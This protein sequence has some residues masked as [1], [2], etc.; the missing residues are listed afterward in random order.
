MEAVEFRLYTHMVQYLVEAQE[1]ARHMDEVLAGENECTFKWFILRVLATRMSGE[2]C[3]SLGNGFANL[4]LLLFAA[5]K[6]KCEV[7]GCVEGDDGIARCERGPA[8]TAE[9]FKKMGL[10]IKLVKHSD[11]ETA[12]F[13]GLIFDTVEKRNVADPYKVLATFA[14]TTSRYA[15]ARN[16]VLAALLRCKAMCLAYQYPGCPILSSLAAYGLRATQG[17]KVSR[18][19]WEYALREHVKWNRDLQELF[20]AGN[21]VPSK[22]ELQSE[23]PPLEYKLKALLDIEV[24]MRTRILMEKVFGVTVLQQLAV[25]RELAEKNDLLP[26]KVSVL[27]FPE[28]WYKYYEWYCIPVHPGRMISYPGPFWTKRAGHA[29]E[30]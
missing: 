4:M 23:R 16:S 14:W 10:I 20:I 25:E 17:V 30:W 1:F 22:N 27:D 5:E 3:T 6:A 11:I 2:M 18:R 12:S 9:F 28:N 26:L 29:R 8:P 24:G 19:Q 15:N 21:L 13:C 7:V